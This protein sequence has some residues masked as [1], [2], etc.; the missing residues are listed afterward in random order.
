MKKFV[1]PII[2]CILCITGVIIGILAIYSNTDQKSGQSYFN[3]LETSPQSASTIVIGASYI[4]VP[5]NATVVTQVDRVIKDEASDYNVNTP[6][7]QSPTSPKQLVPWMEGA[8]VAELMEYAN[9]HVI[10]ITGVPIKK[11]NGNWY[12]P[13]DHGNFIFEVDP[14]KTGPLFSINGSNSDNKIGINTH[15]MNVM[16]PGAIKNN[17]FLVVACGDL[18]GKAKAEMYMAAR[19]INCYAPCD[20]FTANVMGYNGTGV[21]LGGEPI[22]PIINGTG[23]VIGAQPVAINKNELIIVQTTN[24]TYPDQYCDTPKRYFTDLEKVYNIKLNLDVVNANTNQTN[25]IINEAEKTGAN[26]IGVRVET[27]NDKKPIEA[28]LKANPNH[29]AILFHSAAYEPGY[30]L[31]SEFPKQV[32]GQDP[33]PIF[34]KQTSTSELNQIFNQIRSLW[35]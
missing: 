11:I 34:I 32:T 4:K 13:D 16:V 9:V 10:P 35:S 19:G 17:A 24:K 14:S 23:A 31:F 30:S 5:E 8:R 21:I 33:R 2:I 27:N 7:G 1:L 18:P 3:G 12:G 6:P 15:G 22:R 28:W 25:L 26:V 29:R 20:R